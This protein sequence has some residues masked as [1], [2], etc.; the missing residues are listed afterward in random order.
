MADSYDPEKEEVERDSQGN[1]ISI[2][3]DGELV[4]EESYLCYSCAWN[5]EIDSHGPD[6]RRC[7]NCGESRH[8]EGLQREVYEDGAWTDMRDAADQGW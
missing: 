2:H 7:P 4:Y 6:L 5:G 1:L 3:Y 8:L